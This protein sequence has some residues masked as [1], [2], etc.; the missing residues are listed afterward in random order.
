LNDVRSRFPF[1]FTYDI[2]RYSNNSVP[3]DHPVCF[4]I[5]PE[6]LPELKRKR[7]LLQ[8]HHHRCYQSLPHTME[9]QWEVVELV[10]DQMS[11]YA[12]EHFE[13]QRRGAERLLHNRLTDERVRFDM[14][15]AS[16]L[17]CEP[18]DFIGRH[19]QE[20][21]IVMMQR[22]G[23]LFLE[24][25]QLCFPANWSLQFNTGMNFLQIHSPIP[26]FHDQGLAERIKTFLMRIEAGQPWVRRN[27]SLN[28]GRHLDSSLETFHLWGQDRKKVTPDN[29]GELVHLRVEVQKLFR[30]PRSN[31]LLFSIHTHLISLKDLAHNRDWTE[32][33]Y[34][35]LRELP[36]AIADYKG[37]MLFK[38]ATLRYLENCLFG[39]AQ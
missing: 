17:C 9:A 30:L 26:G 4:E 12:P 27:W 34:R 25:G 2:Y 24:A 37:I 3:L 7:Q 16:S 8:E 10:L 32:Q 35:V 36:E 38:E 31:G 13:V 15:D 19:L 14:G 20:D 22:D 33:L 18:L 11:R 6:Y 1:P 29:A 21:L 39:E 5:T 28:A 23:D